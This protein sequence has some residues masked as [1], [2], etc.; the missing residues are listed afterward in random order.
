MLWGIDRDAWIQLWAGLL[1]AIPAAVLSAAVAA[2][3]AVRVLERSN[4]HQKELAGQQLAEQRN[5]AGEVRRKVVMADLLGTTS[6]FTIAAEDGTSAVQA[7]VVLFETNA[8]RWSFEV[9]GRDHLMELLAWNELL[10]EP[11]Y[12]LAAFQGVPGTTRHEWSLFLNETIGAFASIAMALVT[13]Q[14][15]AGSEHLE[16]MKS[17]REELESRWHDDLL[18]MSMSGASSPAADPSSGVTG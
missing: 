13:G 4:R 2:W 6:G 10:W 16:S 11:A 3:V 14:D 18:V 7:Q 12:H 17:K 8:H 15:P 1:G 9:G 5:E